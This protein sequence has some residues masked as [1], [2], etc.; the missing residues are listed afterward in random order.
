MKFYVSCSAIIPGTSSAFGAVNYLELK[1]SD[2][3]F[4]SFRTDYLD[5]YQGQRTGFATPYVSVTLGVTHFFQA[6][7]KCALKFGMKPLLMRTRMIM[8]QKKLN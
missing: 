7:L 5:D 2:K 4:M 3:D 8:E 6:F 1:V